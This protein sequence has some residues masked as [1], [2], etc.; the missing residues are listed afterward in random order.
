MSTSVPV[1]H[2]K[3][4]NSPGAIA[5]AVDYA[6]SV[7]NAFERWSRGDGPRDRRVTVDALRDVRI[8]ELG[9]GHTMG[10]AALL[11]CAG[12]RVTVADRFAAS[13]DPEFH[14]PF[15]EALLAKVEGRGGSFTAPL[16]R[17]LDAND[18]APDVIAC[19]KVGAEDLWRIGEHFDVVLSNAV[20]E[21]VQDLEATA[22]NLAAVTRR[23]GYNFHQVDFR[24]HRDFTRPL[25]YLTVSSAEYAVAREAH[26]CEWGTQWRVSTTSAAFRAAGFDVTVAVNMTADAAYLAD[27]R[28]R[29]HPEFQHLA[30]DD[31]SA[32]SA[33]LVLQRQA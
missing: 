5:S 29:L 10:P 7:A 13:W 1:N 26:F 14:V 3:Q 12:A 30:D 6:I 25:E 11:A 8:L 22:R 4:D 33:L 27:L 31:L 17:L 15:Y 32:I 2:R 21:H 9:P 20:L 19:H 24:D 16:R 18:F 28:P 23:G